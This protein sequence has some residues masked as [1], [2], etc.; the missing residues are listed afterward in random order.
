MSIL[1]GI[2]TEGINPQQAN[3]AKRLVKAMGGV[4]NVGRAAITRIKRKIQNG[5]P[6][7][8]AEQRLFQ[9]YQEGMQLASRM[10]GE[11][12]KGLAQGNFNISHDL[13]I[14]YK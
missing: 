13:H 6:L 5:V 14:N 4:S 11:I 1:N 10:A 8:A 12:K 3:R 9:Q 7:S 2:I